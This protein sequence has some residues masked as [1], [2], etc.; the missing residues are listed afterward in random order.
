MYALGWGQYEVL[1]LC[2]YL[3]FCSFVWVLVCVC[4]RVAIFDQDNARVHACV[5]VGSSVFA[6]HTS[7]NASAAGSGARS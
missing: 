3:F 2:V 6:V 5:M 1:C 4:V 7:A